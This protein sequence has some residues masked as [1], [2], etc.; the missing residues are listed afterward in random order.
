MTTSLE[1]H[2]ARFLPASENILDKNM[3]CSSGRFFQL[4]ET[5]RNHEI[6]ASDGA[7]DTI[8][9]CD[10]ITLSAETD[11]FVDLKELA[12]QLLDMIRVRKRCSM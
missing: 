10:D 6:E 1:Q 2:S 5:E 8:T 9:S 12:G 11:N 3:Q 7:H 4:E